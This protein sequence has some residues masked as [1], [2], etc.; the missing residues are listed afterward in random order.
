MAPIAAV[1][2]TVTALDEVACAVTPEGTSSR[3]SGGTATHTL[4]LHV[5]G[6]GPELATA[7]HIAPF[8]R[9]SAPSQHA[10]AGSVQRWQRSRRHARTP[11]H[12]APTTQHD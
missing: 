9:R 2:L 6:T 11:P 12:A 7:V 8:A 4:P 3:T 10:S 1:Q 5:P